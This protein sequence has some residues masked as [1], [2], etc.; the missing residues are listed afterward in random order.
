MSHAGQGRA[1]AVLALLAGAMA[2]GLTALVPPPTA[3]LTIGLLLVVGF[4]LPRRAASLLA[5]STRRSVLA[6]ALLA[7]LVGVSALSGP[8][9]LGGGV[10]GGSGF[11]G[12][13]GA[14]AQELAVPSSVPVG[15]LATLTSG[16]L[17]AVSLELT[18]RRGIQSALVL[19]V[20]VLGLAGVAAPGQKLIVPFAIGWPAALLALARLSSAPGPV[21]E[22]VMAQLSPSSAPVARW[23]L[24]PVVVALSSAGAVLAALVLSGVSTLAVRT[25]GWDGSPSGSAL[26]GRAASGYLGG[27]LDLSVRGPLDDDP[28]VRVPASSPRLWR[29]GTLDLYDGQRWQASGP[30]GGLPAVVR[31]RAGVLRLA[32]APVGGSPATFEVQPLR[33][34]ATQVLAPGPLL[35]VSSPTLTGGVAAAGD[36]LLLTG[37][38]PSG[39][40]VRSQPLPDVSSLV[41]A[42][43]GRSSPLA[44]PRYLALPAELPGRVR[45]LG[46]RLVGPAPSRA[47]AVIAV[48]RELARRM[49]YE[50][51]SPVPPPGADAVDDVLFTSHAGFCEQF[52]S[53]EIVLLRAAGIPARMAVGFSAA[54]PPKDD[55][56]SLR[57]SDAH[58]WVEV[59][60]PGY[61]WVNSDPTPAATADDSWWGRRW[62]AWSATARSWLRGSLAFGRRH[63]MS[64]SL[65]AGAVV[66]GGFLV[67]PLLSRRG[68]ESP[69]S[70]VDPELA[71]AFARLEADLV[72]VGAARAPTET[73]AM[74]AARLPGDLHEPLSVLE[75]A[76]YAATPPT[77]EEA[78]RAALQLDGH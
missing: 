56:V 3:L 65:V 49:T 77:R 68:R 8:D 20:A 32:P 59:W 69:P 76:L 7:A 17:V 34:G 12:A 6:F 64:A 47:A 55:R 26:P 66:A 46:H 36:R 13:L 58:A 1:P 78:R 71:A 27:D 67:V 42:P 73:V 9:A 35:T 41:A 39:Y 54:G 28:L 33:R 24:M 45:E 72:T 22:P 31:E 53:A 4:V 43:P 2:L 21:D 57:R 70:R 48:E 18:D 63:W 60:F 40:V 5:D 16:S 23:Q 44:D 29:A 51:D 11:A 14:A 19:S 15:L 10:F 75:R 62:T 38:A 25:G 50:L 37:P 74:L 52:A 61:G 30:P